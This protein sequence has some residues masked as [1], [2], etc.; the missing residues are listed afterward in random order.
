MYNIHYTNQFKKDYKLVLR[1]GNK[2]SIIKTVVSIITK[3]ELLPSKYKQHKLSGKYV[4]CW[5]CHL[6]PDWL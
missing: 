3:K 5:E 4:D 2:E 1:R 6:T